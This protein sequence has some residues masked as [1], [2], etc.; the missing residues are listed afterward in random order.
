MSLSTTS[1]RVT[2]TGAGAS[3]PFAI[4]YGMTK[5]SQLQ[6]T[7][8]VDATGVPTTFVEGVDYTVALTDPNNLPTTADVTTT[9]N[10]ESGETLIV[11]RF[12]DLTQLTVYPR[13]GTFPAKSHENALDLLTMM[14]Q[15]LANQVGGTTYAVE[16]Q[17]LITKDSGNLDQWDA[18][19][20]VITNVSTPVLDNDAATK[21]F[22]EATLTGSGLLPPSTAVNDILVG[23]GTAFIVKTAAQFCDLYDGDGLKVVAG[24]FALDLAAL[25]GLEISSGSLRTTAL[26]RD[27]ANLTL[28][29]GDLLQHDGSNIVKFTATRGGILRGD[30]TPKLAELALGTVNQSLI[31]DG[32][33][34]VYG[35]PK[36][37]RK[38]IAEAVASTSAKLSFTTGIT[39]FDIYEIELI[40]ILPDVASTTEFWMRMEDSGGEITGASDYE[41]TNEHGDTSDAAALRTSYTANQAIRLT[42]ALAGSYMDTPANNVLNGLLR[43]YRPSNA[44]TVQPHVRGFVN[45]ENDAG[46]IEIGEV[47]GR[48]IHAGLAAVTGFHFLMRTNNIESGTIR[49]YGITT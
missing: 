11:D 41:G 6:V 34:L 12:V 5:T 45:Y 35:T 22:V 25:G 31:S 14:A 27:I 42:P 30:S 10:V 2:F 47:L 46:R 43:V 7:K 4:P 44:A 48:C 1:V 20:S 18:E 26:L 9:A 24:Q 28:A 37:Q 32:T 13:G 19:S 38:F 39:G 36:G 17:E 33:D 3:G 15:Q 16:Q 49:V 21:A 29:N 40:D 23:N 8:K